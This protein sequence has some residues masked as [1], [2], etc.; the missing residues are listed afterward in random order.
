MDGADDGEAERAGGQAAEQVGITEV[1]VHER[2]L[3]AG[4]VAADR[5]QRMQARSTREVKVDRRAPGRHQWSRGWVAV[6]VG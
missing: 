1:G 4:D 2:G 6:Q 3:A 5:P